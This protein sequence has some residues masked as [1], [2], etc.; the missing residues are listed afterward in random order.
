MSFFR[1]TAIIIFCSLLAACGFHLRG[2]QPVP[3]AIR[4]MYLQ[5][6]QP[7]G[8]FEQILRQTLPGYGIRLTDDPTE[9]PLTLVILSAA[10]L[11]VSGVATSTLQTQQYSL[12]YQV[13]FQV[14]SQ[15]GEIIIP[16]TAVVSTTTFT[17]GVTQML[18]AS[19]YTEQ[20]LTGLEHDAAFRL[21]NRLIATNNLTLIEQY[22]MKHPNETQVRT[23][24]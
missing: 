5:S 14:I 24:N 20:F 11:P 1:L 16:N 4:V 2:T 15:R 6:T 19:T 23:V 22:E 3:Q 9:A 8:P 17:A 13:N 21:V 12:S 18:S 7:Y 10:A